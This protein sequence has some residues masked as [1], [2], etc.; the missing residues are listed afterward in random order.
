MFL[1]F[2]I[3][4]RVIKPFFEHGAGKYFPVM[5][6]CPQCYPPDFRRKTIHIRLWK[7]TAFNQR[8]LIVLFA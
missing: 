8:T 2:V 5:V 1:L 4:K 7:Y 6:D 3:V